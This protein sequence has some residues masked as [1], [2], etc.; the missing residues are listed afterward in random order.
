MNIVISILASLGFIF[1]IVLVI[2]A[3]I[4]IKGIEVDN[5]ELKGSRLGGIFLFSVLPV[6]T[7]FIIYNHL[8]G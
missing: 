5:M 6:I 7:F 4:K 1:L 2:M 8:N 3:F